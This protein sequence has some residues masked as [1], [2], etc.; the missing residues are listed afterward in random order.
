MHWILPCIFLRRKSF[1]EFL[2][3]IRWFITYLVSN[4]KRL[5]YSIEN[6][7]NSRL[8]S[9][10]KIITCNSLLTSRA[11]HESYGFQVPLSIPTSFADPWHFCKDPDQQPWL[12]DKVPDPD[13]FVS[14]LL[15]GNKKINFLQVIL[16]IS[17]WRNKN[18]RILGILLSSSKNSKKNLH[19]SCFVT[20]SGLF[21]FEKWCKCS[22]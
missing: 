18:T 2:Q 6:G 1:F 12:T 10:I 19:S 11:V 14:D 9:K 15:D 21:I 8:L 17:F 4:N 7:K 13:K 5:R 3:D 20:S 16:L 22:F